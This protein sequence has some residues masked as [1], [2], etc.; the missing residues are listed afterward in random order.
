[1]EQGSGDSP[2]SP[3]F[4]PLIWSQIGSD[5]EPQAAGCP[6]PRVPVIPAFVGIKASACGFPHTVVKDP[7]T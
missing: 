1:M 5:R 3:T 2:F 6:A 7:G 4:D